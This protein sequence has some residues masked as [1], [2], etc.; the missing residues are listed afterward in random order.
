MKHIIL[1]IVGVLCLS[2]TA[3]A[4]DWFVN[5][6]HDALDSHP[7]DRVCST[8][9]TLPDGALECTLRAAL[10]EA[11]VRFATTPRH[12]VYVPA[13]IYHLTLHTVAPD[14]EDERQLLLEWTAADAIVSGDLDVQGDVSIIGDGE[15]RTIINGGRRDRVFD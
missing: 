13:G 10:Q 9:V 8:G 2:S 5:S 15:G 11:N 6:T 4:D 1:T 3:F 7:G 12:V 14:V